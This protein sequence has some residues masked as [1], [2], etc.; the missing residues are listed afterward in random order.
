MPSRRD[1]KLGQVAPKE[2]RPGVISPPAAQIDRETL[3]EHQERLRRSG[4]PP[5]TREEALLQ[6]EADE[7]EEVFGPEGGLP[8]APP[9]IRYACT[10]CGGT[11]PPPGE[12]R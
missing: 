7:V 4:Y 11:V 1:V 2:I 8:P 10:M 9:K 6:Y 12:E 3:E 5:Y